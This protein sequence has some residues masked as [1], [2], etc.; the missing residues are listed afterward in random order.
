M[1]NNRINI[2]DNEQV[3]FTGN[4]HVSGSIHRG[5]KVIVKNGSLT[6]G[7]SIEDQT[8]IILEHDDNQMHL[9]LVVEGS[10]DNNVK[11]TTNSADIIIGCRIGHNCEFRTNAGSIHTFNIE[12]DVTLETKSGFISVGNVAMGAIIKSTSGNISAQTVCQYSL[13]ESE[14]GSIFVLSQLP[15]VE[16]KTKTGAI[17]VGG[18][19]IKSVDKQQPTTDLAKMSFI[20]SKK[21]CA[22]GI[23]DSEEASLKLM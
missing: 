10:V 16:L 14:S 6:V 15:R 20:N 8:E 12:R 11:L 7:G 23:Q 5:A 4:V 22:S 13:L 21:I 18:I 1:S 3:E 17:Y 2:L 9:K 19:K